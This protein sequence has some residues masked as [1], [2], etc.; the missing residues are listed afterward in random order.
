MRLEEL[1][2]HIDEDVEIQGFVE[3]IRN[4]K[5]V[6]F[7]VIKDSTFKI[8]VTIEKSVEENKE[9]VEL[10]NNLTLDSTVK[11]KGK[12]VKNENVK[13]NG[14]EIIPSSITITSKS[15]EELPFNYR[16]LDNVN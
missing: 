6:Q 12:L 10:V 4:I 3:S 2:N 7:L 8:Q 11:I 5:W 15:L 9:M 16:D 1:I 14:M 13:L